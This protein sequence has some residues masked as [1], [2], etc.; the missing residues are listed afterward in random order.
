MKSQV[1]LRRLAIMGVIV[2]AGLILNSCAVYA[3]QYQAS[4]PVSEIVKMSK[5]G[6]PSKN[7][8][9][10]IRSSHS[11]YEL[12]ASDLAKLKNEGVQDSVL[13]YMQ[14]TQLDAV[15]RDQRY[16]D[17]GYGYP[18]MPWNPYYGFG[19]PYYGFGYGL[20]YRYW[21]WGSGPVIEKKKKKKKKKVETIKRR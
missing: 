3:P 21:G 18:G 6:V 11:V 1:I 12:P 16:Q 19:Y 14:K 13:N 4:L 15:R 8:I 9:R 2:A 20:P 10:Q 7:I 17:S 5:D